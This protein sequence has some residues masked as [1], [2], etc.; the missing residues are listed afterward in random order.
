MLAVVV[1]AVI[2]VKLVNSLDGDGEWE[3]T[4]VIIE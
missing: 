1:V 4:M 3:M 2:M